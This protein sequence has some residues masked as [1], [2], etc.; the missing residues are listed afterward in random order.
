MNPN[1]LDQEPHILTD[2][3]SKSLVKE[4]V[5]LLFKGMGNDCPK[6]AL[7]GRVAKRK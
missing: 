7:S 5:L 4:R 6:G 1:S 2:Y 3:T